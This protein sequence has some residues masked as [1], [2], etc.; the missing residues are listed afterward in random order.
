MRVTRTLIAF[1]WAELC[2]PIV[3]P[4]AGRQ[5][6]LTTGICGDLLAC[7]VV[8]HWMTFGCFRR[9]LHM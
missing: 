8:V 6:M 1:R 3:D 7:V 4:R 5:K 2:S 9:R